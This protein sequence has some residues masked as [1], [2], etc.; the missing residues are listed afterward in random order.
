MLDAL[1]IFTRGGVVLF[2]PPRMA[3]TTRGA[4]FDAL[5]RDVL[6]EERGDVES[7]VYNAPGPNP[8]SYVVRWTNDNE[9]NLVVAAAHATMVSVPYLE[10]LLNDVKA[11][12]GRNHF[13]EGTL[14]YP[15]FDA[16]FAKMLAEAED[17]ADLRAP[18]A[19]KRPPKSAA[20]AASGPASPSATTAGGG[21]DGAAADNNDASTAFDISRLRRKGA[22]TA[23]ASPSKPDSGK[24]GKQARDWS[25]LRGDDDV[26]D[27]A[28]D[29][30]NPADADADADAAHAQPAASLVASAMDADDDDDS[31]R[32]KSSA[33]TA[34][35]GWLSQAMRFASGGTELD[36]QDIA[37]VLETL[38]SK[39][40]AKNVAQEIATKLCDSVRSSLLGKKRSALTSLAG[41]VERAVEDALVRILT[42]KRSI[43]VLRDA[44]RAKADGR[45]YSIAFIGVNGVGKSTNLAKVAHWLTGHG[46]KV[47]LCACDTFRSGAVE[48]LRTHATRLGVPLFER[49]YEKDPSN[50]AREGLKHAAT[51]GVDVVLIDTAGRMQDNEP[52]MRALAKLVHA[53]NP[54]LVLFVG[55]MLVGN[56]AVDQLTKFHQK[57]IDLCPV[58]NV[59]RSVDGICLTK[60]D[61]VDDKVGAALSMVYVS[62]APIVF[63]GT[64]QGYEDLR[65]LSTAKLVSQLMN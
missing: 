13:K 23:K 40:M 28:L 31:A 24:K 61:T 15:A 54:D 32:S 17:R 27:D 53:N 26:G 1:A 6:L 25:R 33:T 49:G 56:D 52:L 11:E 55:E 8:A 50:V 30:S 37:P 58:G 36:M 4:P 60:Y 46:L 43:D 42:P 21:D 64:G 35:R 51:A 5:V 45:V 2:A 57:L 16:V 59:V 19:A 47:M 10:G 39:L 3:A 62:G 20:P 48:Q 12:F 63:V 38:R 9:R 41:I 34:Q 22:T 7:F 29:F 18:K 65:K 14:A 44:K